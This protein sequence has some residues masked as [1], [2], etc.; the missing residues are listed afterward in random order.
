MTRLLLAAALLGAL[1][2]VGVAATRGRAEC[3]MSRLHGCCKKARQNRNAPRLGQARL[4]CIVNCP[5]P[6]PSGTNFTFQSPNGTA[7]PQRPHAA[8]APDAPALAQAPA[9]VRHAA[10]LI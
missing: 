5:Q 7:T 6:A 2:G 8:A 3:P 10:F 4:C 9:Y 1:P